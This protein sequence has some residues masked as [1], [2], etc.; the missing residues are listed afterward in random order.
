MLQSRLKTGGYFVT[1]Q[2]CENFQRHYAA[3]HPASS[4]APA[5]AGQTD[6]APVAPAVTEA[7]TPASVVP[8]PA[9]ANAPEAAETSNEP[10]TKSLSELAAV[11]ATEKAV[12]QGVSPSDTAGEG[13]SVD[14]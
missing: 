1:L 2:A 5:P 8:S 14:L 13:P 10:P 12:E 6:P 4:P 3:S 9:S 7:Q 11:A